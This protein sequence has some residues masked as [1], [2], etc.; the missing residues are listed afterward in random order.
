MNSLN[1]RDIQINPSLPNLKLD[2]YYDLNDELGLVKISGANSKAF[3][4]GQLTC[5]LEQITETQPGFSAHC[6]IKGRMVSL[7]FLFL[8]GEDYYYLLPNS[9][10]DIALNTLKKY[11]AFSKVEIMLCTEYCIYGSINQPTDNCIADITLSD[12]HNIILR[13]NK[14][15]ATMRDLNDWH[16]S[17]I[18]NR[19]PVITDK[20]SGHFIPQMVGLEKLG[21]LSFTKGCFLGQE[22]I[23]RTQHLGKLKRHMQLI[24]SD[25]EMSAGDIIEKDGNEFGEIVLAAKSEDTFFAL[26]VLKN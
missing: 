3:L 11:A 15:D 4:Q 19:I 10:C 6:N 8:I 22:I 5:D 25:C 23:A 16:L 21:G 12:N 18:E 7:G 24:K 14:I 17:L 9:I 20:T 13:E 2:G 26:A 1:S